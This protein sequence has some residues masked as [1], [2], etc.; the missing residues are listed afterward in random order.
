[1][2]GNASFGYWVR[3][4]RKALDLTQA[5]LA[6]QVGCAEGTIRMIEADAR[7]PSR[8]IAA[9]LAEQLA[10]A[11]ADHGAFIGAARAELSIDR[12]APPV[13]HASHAPGSTAS[14][15]PGGTVTFVFTDIVG[16]TALWEQ[17]PQTMP[18]A[19]ARHTAILREA[20]ATHG[21]VVFK[22]MGDAA[23]AAFASAPAA[24]TAALAAQRALH[25]EPWGAT[26][27]LRARMAL[28]TGSAEARD[29]DYVGVP[30]SRV[31]RL[32]SAGHGGQIL[33][34]LAT[35]ELV[36]EHLPPEVALH[37]LGE[38]RLKD[39]SY[40][41]QIYQLA[42]PDLPA[43]FPP[44]MT[45]ESRHTNL[46][47]QPTALIGRVREVQQVCALL[48]TPDVRL[49]TLTGPGG[50]G[51]TR[52]ALQVAVE[53][54]DDFADGIYVVNLAPI[55]DA[56]LVASVIAQTLGVREP[57]RRP[58]LTS[59]KDHLR[60]KHML[61]LLDNFE[62]LV[63][64]AALVADL[65]ASCARLSV[66]V[67]SRE[68]LHLRGEKEILVP[69]LALPPQE[70]PR[71][72]PT[73]NQE[74]AL[75]AGDMV[76]S[77]W[78]SVLSS[79]EA[80]TQ[81]A[82]VELF[83]ARARDVKHDFAVSNQS[84]PV[85]AEI[86][87][88]LDGLPLA[89][90]L[91][92]ARIKLLAPQAL[93]EQLGDRLKLLTGGARDLPS[94]QQTLRNTLDWSYH[95]LDAGEQALFRRLGVFV[96]GWALEA[97]EAVCNADCDLPPDA[98]DGLAALVDKSLLRQTEGVNDEARFTL[99]ETTREYALERL[100][101]SGEAEALRWRHAGYYLALA[102]TAAPQLHGAEQLTWL[103]RLEA[104]HDN[105][106]AALAWSQAA[107]DGRSTGL[108][109]PAEVG[110]RLA[111][112]LAWFWFV[113]GY[114]SEGRAWLAGALARGGEAPAL[115]RATTLNW[116]GLLAWWPGAHATARAHYEASLSIGRALGDKHTIAAALRGLGMCALVQ[117]R[118]YGGAEALY[119][120]SLALFREL[121]DEWNLG[122]GLH[123]LGLSAHL[124]RD[125]AR[126]SALYDES[127]ALFRRL[128][129]SSDIAL[130][131]L[132]LGKT[133]RYQGDYG[134]AEPLYE[135][136]LALS[137]YLRDRWIRAEALGHLGNLARNRRDY[138]RAAACY[139][140]SLALFRDLGDKEG[141]A[142]VLQDQGYLAHQ[143][144]D[145]TRAAALLVESLALCH[146]LENKG[147][148]SG[149]LQ[150][151]VEWPWRRGS[152]NARHGCSAR[153][154]HCSRSLTQSW[155]RPTA[156]PMGVAL[157][158]HALSST[159]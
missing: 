119:D 69:P 98:L 109:Q 62:Q 54:L 118:D 22:T 150:A 82:A 21:G 45:F 43:E 143:Q 152:P 142:S 157:A 153:Q 60:G 94:R 147:S 49:L 64:A 86:C 51:K 59:L 140:E 23:C 92:A 48:R 127:L 122:I 58:L 89:I 10:I 101:I 80:F 47:A 110:L 55:S 36:R 91:A 97:V 105:F 159:Q 158:S 102:E 79:V 106:R 16:S 30:L 115:V 42:A 84:A 61:L 20:I 103:D 111:G 154:R 83:I 35:K 46:P 57:T 76:L 129:D 67:T 1:M 135:E 99:L 148:V 77:S 24:L 26:G 151:W 40:P 146:E 104:E 108:A 100:E 75:A 44:L 39:L 156:P 121:G 50:V 68:L 123:C 63:V 32:L 144:G 71:G 38:H 133:A 141:T 27:P 96:G 29:G 136:C 120:E 66:L 95:L 138:D 113:R 6:R 15:L 7:R 34:S 25:A 2:D 78:F 107:A 131:L 145:E 18:V 12:L 13:Q 112:A 125:Y 88:R 8:Q 130:S 74:S 93:L 65:L 17:H 139:D 73:K 28:H 53:L 81:Y 155:T 124:Q 56:G 117:Q 72:Y 3:R 4:Q 85:V 137:H 126:A 41:E 128:R 87:H 70:P 149:V 19:L 116:M 132:W 37:S 31:A 90:E 52:L 14:D 134:R 11:P 5:E 114:W 33:L 9:R